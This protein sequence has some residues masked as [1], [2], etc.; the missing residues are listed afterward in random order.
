[1][2][3]LKDRA[4]CWMRSIDRSCSN[5]VEDAV[6][7][8][9]CPQR[10]QSGTDGFEQCADCIPRVSA[11]TTVRVQLWLSCR[12]TCDSSL[13]FGPRELTFGLL[14]QRSPHSTSSSPVNDQVSI[15]QDAICL[16]A[17]AVLRRFGSFCLQILLCRPSQKAQCTEGCCSGLS[18]SA[19]ATR[20]TV[21][22]SK[23]SHRQCS[24]DEG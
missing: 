5:L 17:S 12:L 11:G 21:V 3:R 20:P 1:M 4:T 23:G 16:V 24:G 8:V 22:R 14:C 9:H 2:A 10:R 19:I 7:L 15:N 13:N 6:E 18:T